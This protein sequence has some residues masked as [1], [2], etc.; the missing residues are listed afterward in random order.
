MRQQQSL[1]R[2]V[3]QV[4]AGLHSVAGNNFTIFNGNS[5]AG[6]HFKLHNYLH[7][8]FKHSHYPWSASCWLKIHITLMVITRPNK[9]VHWV[10]KS[11][12]SCRLYL[13]YLVFCSLQIVKLTLTPS[14]LWPQLY[15]SQLSI[16]SSYNNLTQQW[17][18]TGTPRR[19][20]NLKSST[21]Y[22]KNLKKKLRP[23]FETI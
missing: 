13:A 18:T 21:N 12:E 10:N 6:K 14:P 4:S 1:A 11:V 8:S 3:S 19:P 7:F 5:C 2:L 16:Q 17:A 9:G 23:F 20:L 15:K 22:F